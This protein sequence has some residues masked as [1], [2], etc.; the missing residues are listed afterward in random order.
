MRVKWV[1]SLRTDLL[2]KFD[3]VNH[4]ILVIEFNVFVFDKPSLEFMHSFI[5]NEKKRKPKSKLFQ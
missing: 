4:I 5:P 1:Q 2:N 3:R